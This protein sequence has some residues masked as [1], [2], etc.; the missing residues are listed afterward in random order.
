METWLIALLVLAAPAALGAF[1]TYLFCRVR[2]LA[3]EER[4]HESQRELRDMSEQLESTGLRLQAALD[5]K[6]RTEQDAKRLPELERQATDQ[7]EENLKLKEQVARLNKER[8]VSEEMTRRLEQAEER[9]RETFQ[10]LASQALQSNADEF[11]KHARTQLDDIFHQARGDWNLQKTE[12]QMLVQPLEQTLETLNSQVREME[13]EREGAYQKLQEQLCQLGQT[14]EQLQMS[15]ATLVQAL[16]APGVRGAWGEIQLRRLVEMAGMM[17]HVD[18][19]EQA[20]NGERPDMIVHLP[21][22]VILP[23]DAKTSMQAYLEAMEV[24]DDQLREA[25]LDAHPRAMRQRI[26]ELGERR[27]RQQFE[28][29]AEV[30]VMFV[31][32]DACLSAAFE[33]D[34][35]L[36]EY[37]IQQGVLL[38]TPVTLL[39]LLKAVAYGW[40]Q[41]QVA[42]NA[43]QIAFQGKQLYKYLSTF[44]HNL[45]DLGG[46]LDQA[47]Q[48]YNRAVGS[49][50]SRVLP[51]AR[52]LR[53]MGVADMGLPSA[54]P[55]VHQAIPPASHDLDDEAKDGSSPS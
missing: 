9:L 5:S 53:E 2:R 34:P 19:N 1:V 23:V 49:L 3:V 54:A 17:E 22:N 36:L 42:E 45:G 8:E 11:L 6:A 12:F 24:S 35:D 25:K 27:Q 55:V 41:H 16:K 48:D 15:T 28:R 21:N 33:R 52:R 14:H 18:F 39:A 20:A 26:Q 29:T 47:V 46:R 50:E 43:R 38:T 30:V 37:A 40:Q 44:L 10:A 13:Q 4:L 51:A 7:R 32:N 31:P